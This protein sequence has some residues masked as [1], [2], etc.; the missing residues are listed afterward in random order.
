MKNMPDFPREAPCLLCADRHAGGQGRPPCAA[1]VPI[2]KQ[3]SPPQ[4][5]DIMKLIKPKFY[6]KGAIL[7]SPGSEATS[8]NIVRRGSVKLY[9]LTPGGKEKL[10][11]VLRS[12]DF[13]GET[14]L[15][16]KA[17]H[18]Q[19]AAALSDVY[20]CS[21]DREDFQNVLL[22]Y[23]EIALSVLAE[24]TRRLEYA[25]TQAGEM[26]TDSAETRLARFLLEKLENQKSG[27][28]K[29]T[30][31]PDA[32]QASQAPVVHLDMK[33]KDIASHLGM[34]PETLSR[35][36]GELEN[37]G[38]ISQLSLRKIALL[39]LEALSEI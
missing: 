31:A 21:I 15:T 12:G 7:F 23:P 13:T 10:V 20:I 33:R 36:I 32:A 18:R 11:R 27:A 16:G 19:F 26:A 4:L 35:K 22:K 25:E 37:K 39:D 8:L 3:L 6:P 9:T 38:L 5:E 30:D 34:T 2:F 14:A 17:K 29:G 28:P 1:R 24:L